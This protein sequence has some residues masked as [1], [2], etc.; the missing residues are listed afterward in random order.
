MQVPRLLI[1]V[2][3]GKDVRLTL[4]TWVYVIILVHIRHLDL[5]SLFSGVVPESSP[6]ILACQKTFKCN[7]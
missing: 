4:K 6:S 7:I 5:Y 2:G 1:E 3:A